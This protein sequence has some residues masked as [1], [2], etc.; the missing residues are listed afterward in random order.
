MTKRTRLKGVDVTPSNDPLEGDEVLAAALRKG[1]DFTVAEWV[2]FVAERLAGGTMRMTIVGDLIGRGID[3]DAAQK[4]VRLVAE[5]PEEQRAKRAGRWT[6][7]PE[8]VGG[9]LWA[10]FGLFLGFFYY[11][12]SDGAE[13]VLLMLPLPGFA[14]AGI[15]LYRRLH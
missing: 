13:F 2:R 6:G 8:I 10:L 14:I 1:G 3:P 12:M 4:L 5:R 9:L 11:V 7:I 15:G